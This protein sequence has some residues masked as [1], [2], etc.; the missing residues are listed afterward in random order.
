MGRMAFVSEWPAMMLCLDEKCSRNRPAVQIDPLDLYFLMA[1]FDLG[2]DQNARTAHS[3]GS[4]SGSSRC[5]QP[6]TTS[7]EKVE[8]LVS[9]TC[10]LGVASTYLT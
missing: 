1:R 6:I 3:F 10:P 4:L 5:A 7:L 9:F 8:T 2:R